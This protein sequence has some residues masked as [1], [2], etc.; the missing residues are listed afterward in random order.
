MNPAPPVT[1]QFDIH[2]RSTEIVF[3]R[4][5]VDNWTGFAEP[6]GRYFKLMYNNIQADLKIFSVVSYRLPFTKT[7]FEYFRIIPPGMGVE[8]GSMAV[9]YRERPEFDAFIAALYLQKCMTVSSGKP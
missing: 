4:I 1:S 7:L 3:G 9:L 6:R 2:P 8:V 5:I